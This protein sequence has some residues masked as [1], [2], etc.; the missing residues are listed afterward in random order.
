MRI[1]E[2]DGSTAALDVAVEGLRDEAHAEGVAHGVEIAQQN[3]A[4]AI[5]DAALRL[6]AYREEAAAALA[7]TSVELAIEIARH[8]VCAE[9]ESGRHDVTRIVRETLQ[10]S[11]VGRGSCVVHVHPDDAKDLAN[12]PFRSGTR[13][14]PDIGVKRG[15]VHVDTPNGLF[16]RDLDDALAA[17]AERILESLR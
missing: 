12:T 9:V 7:E 1:V 17:I 3:A 16:V 5:E 4:K 2:A 8:L 10:A 11:A 6:D 13:V 14:E 15:D